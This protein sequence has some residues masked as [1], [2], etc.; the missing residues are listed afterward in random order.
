MM[1]SQNSTATPPLPSDVPA[2]KEIELASLELE[3]LV[4]GA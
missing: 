2:P 4:P 3:N 1:E